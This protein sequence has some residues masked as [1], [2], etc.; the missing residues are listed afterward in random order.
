MT[1]VVWNASSG[2]KAHGPFANVTEE[3]LRDLLDR[4]GID[5]RICATDSEEAAVEAVRSAVRAGDKLIIAAGGDG[6][7][8]TVAGE[9]LGNTDVAIGI[10]PLGSVMN[11]ARM[12]AVPRDLEQAADVLAAATTRVIDVGEANGR[13]F[14]EAASVGLSAAM[15]SAAQHF[16]NGDWGSPLRAIWVAFRYVPARVTIELDSQTVSTRALMVAVA[17]GAFMGLG[18][19]VAPGARLDDGQ[20]DVRVFKH[21]SKFELIRHLASIT[22]GRRAYVPHVDT[23]RSERVRIT[24][25]HNLPARADA[26]DLGTTPIE[27]VARPKALRVVVGPDY[28]DGQPPAEKESGAEAA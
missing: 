16:E 24:G 28:A 25:R 27:C 8:D 18:M 14:Y 15:F 9:L 11:V 12:L 13:P 26:M 1:V 21:F 17:N 3:T 6:T 10:L 20:L 2:K 22:F 23:Y 7:F 5:A 4:H 19:T